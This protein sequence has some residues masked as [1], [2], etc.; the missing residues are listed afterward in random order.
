M[1]GIFS[2]SIQSDINGLGKLGY[3]EIGS[4]RYAGTLTLSSGDIERKVRL[5]VG[6]GRV[7]W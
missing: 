1:V 4:T 3:T 6:T 7:R 2:D 5:G